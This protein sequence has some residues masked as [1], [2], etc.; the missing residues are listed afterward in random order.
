MH[1][2]HILEPKGFSTKAIKQLNRLGNV[3]LH[4]P[5]LQPNRDD[6]SV[7][8]IPVA[9]LKN[10]TVLFVRLAHQI[11]S[12]L[13]D[14]M[15]NL[16]Y[17]VSPTTGLDHI[18]LSYLGS[19]NIQVISLKG[20]REFLDTIQATS[21][22]TWGLLLSLMRNIP[23]SH[24]SL[25]AGSRDRDLFKGNELDSK[26][27]GIVGFGR[28]GSKMANYAKAFGMKVLAY[29]TDESIE[30]EDVEFVDHLES[31][32]S[33]VDIVSIHL[34]LTPQ[35]K[36][37]INANLLTKMRSGSFLINT[38]RGDLLDHDAVLRSLNSGQLA[39]AALDVLPEERIK[40]SKIIGKLTNYANNN[41]NLILTPH[42]GGATFESME[43]TEL[44]VTEKLIKTIESGLD[45]P[46]QQSMAL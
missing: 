44:F 37:M 27:L 20:E 22:F 36:Q 17:L 23:A 41:S 46:I 26:T 16:K 21:E 11:D 14:S 24:Q 4:P 1:H 35:T 19:R 29:D 33:K 10:A 32:M 43:K 38:A 30:A 2:I 13:L 39:G 34:P 28:I 7:E 25:L 9:G 42:L 18:D 3:S 31:L 15:P 45:Q 40:D 6:G 8:K 12:T 5:H